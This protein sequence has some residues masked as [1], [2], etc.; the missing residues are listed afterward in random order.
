MKHASILLIT[1]LAVAHCLEII[2]VT[3]GPDGNEFH[4]SQI[5]APSNTTLRF[6]LP[7]SFFSI[8]QSTFDQPCTPL[9]GGFNSGF[10]SGN[11]NP[12]VLDWTIQDS[13]QPIWF[14]YQNALQPTP[15]DEDIVGVINSP[16]TSQY[17]EFRQIAKNANPHQSHS[18]HL[19][20]LPACPTSTD[21]V[22]LMA[23][24]SPLPQLSPNV[25]MTSTSD[26]TTS[27]FS[28]LPQLSPTVPMTSTSDPTTSSFSP[29]PQ[30]PPTVP[31]TTTSDPTTSSFSP[32]PQSLPTPSSIPMTSTSDPAMSFSQLQLSSTSDA[33]S[34]TPTDDPTTSSFSSLS[35]LLPTSSLIPMSFTSNPATS[36]FSPLP[37]LLPTSSTPLPTQSPARRNV[38]ALIAGTVVGAFAGI[39]ALIVLANV[40]VLLYRR[41]RDNVAYEDVLVQAPRAPPPAVAAKE[42]REDAQAAPPGPMEMT[43]VPG[44]ES[45]LYRPIQ[46]NGVPFES[47]PEMRSAAMQP[48]SMQS[49]TVPAPVMQRSMHASR[50]RPHSQV[51]APTRCPL[52]LSSDP[53]ANVAR[54]L[55]ADAVDDRQQWQR[56]QQYQQNNRQRTPSI[57]RSRH[58]QSRADSIITPM[59]PEKQPS[60]PEQ[61]IEFI[62]QEVSSLIMTDPT[63]AD[64]PASHVS[65]SSPSIGQRSPTLGFTRKSPTINFRKSRPSALTR[66]ISRGSSMEGG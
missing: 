57:R 54:P 8:V 17:M 64:R 24:F 32:L 59:I 31:M 16:S 18:A 46:S 62:A 22:I 51:E 23:S 58:R 45:R 7:S 47:I 27:S 5:S 55:S 10:C 66:S 48:S 60:I 34:T 3:V 42:P 26:P 11:L 1:T 40:A 20:W 37:K 12:S 28:P 4:P 25:P 19:L 49:M 30:L 21:N 44:D 36:T 53:F 43:Q 65:Y 15:C 35:Q 61:D 9:P 13:T 39:V 6:L 56:P 38:G 2:T 14:F 52:L 33:V 50:S 63:P 41:W 29:L